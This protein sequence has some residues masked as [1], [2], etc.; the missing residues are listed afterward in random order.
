MACC[1]PPRSGYATAAAVVI[2]TGLAALAA[3]VTAAALADLRTEQSWA[4]RDRDQRRLESAQATALGV[5]MVQ[6]GDGRLFWRSEIGGMTVD[7]MAE[8]EGAKRAAA[9]ISGPADRP[10]AIA[11][12]TPDRWF[13]RLAAAGR[14]QGL[15]ALEDADP[16]PAWRACGVSLISPY[17]RAEA[18]RE[19]LP[20]AAPKAAAFNRRAGQVWRVRAVQADGVAEDRVWRFTGKPGALTY[21]LERRRQTGQ[22]LGDACAAGA[23]P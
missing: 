2:A 12:A 3:A 7:I 18:W 13:E 6:G 23:A 5:L 9:S 15:F 8:P 20:A 19:P 21:L 16:S 11:L 1:Q 14:A 4:R 17:G 10:T 22:V